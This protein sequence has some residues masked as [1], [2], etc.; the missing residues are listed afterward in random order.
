MNVS[1]YTIKDD[2]K[3]VTKTLGNAV[4][5][6]NNI[7]PFDPL[8]EQEPVLILNY[9]SA[10]DGVNYAKI[11][12]DGRDWY[13][14]VDQPILTSGNS[15]SLQLRIDVLMTNR[16]ELLNL[17]VII[18]RS[19][20]DYNS[21]MYDDKQMGQVNRTTFSTV[22]PGHFGT[23]NTFTYNGQIYV[24]AIGGGGVSDE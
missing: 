2:P 4:I 8:S 18:Q 6:R 5:T 19:S 7:Q 24:A 13:Y 21:Y 17:D 3:K 12:K 10:Y 11:T 22:F 9:N 23:G 14:F 16:A 15:V 20:T 1:F